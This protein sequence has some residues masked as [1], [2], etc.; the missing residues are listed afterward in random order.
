MKSS[1]PGCAGLIVLPFAI[2]ITGVVA[3]AGLH[4]LGSLLGL[5]WENESGLSVTLLIICYIIVLIFGMKLYDLMRSSMEKKAADTDAPYRHMIRTHCTAV[6]AVEFEGD[7]DGDYPAGFLVE[8]SNR[9]VL[10]LSGYYLEELT[11]Y[12]TDPG[13]NV[14]SR[15]PNTDFVVWRHREK[16]YVIS[17]DC[18]GTYLPP[19]KLFT[20]EERRMD[21]EVDW[22]ADGQVLNDGFENV[23][24]HLT[25]P[26]A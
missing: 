24:G 8:L 25:R 19:Q 9:R 7:P 5:Q 17:I 12:D 4:E 22:P 6:R 16:G 11:L 23:I 13:V 18:L 3:Y 1:L 26:K 2:L 21:S 20:L 14:P 15:F 10:S